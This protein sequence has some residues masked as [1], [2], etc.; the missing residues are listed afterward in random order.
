MGRGAGKQGHPTRQWQV[1]RSRCPKPAPRRR[2]FSVPGRRVPRGSRARRPGPTCPWDVRGRRQRLSRVPVTPV[3]RAGTSGTGPAR[4][5]PHPGKWKEAHPS[6][7]ASDQEP[8]REAPES[9]T[10]C[11]QQ[12]SSGRRRHRHLCRALGGGCAS[13]VVTWSQRRKRTPPGGHDG[14][15]TPPSA[16]GP[17]H[18][19]EWSTPNNT[20]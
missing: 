8:L 13:G 14:N 1:T 4:S 18:G 2:E 12:H 7:S 5:G 6:R 19:S 3:R 9:P 15:D 11:G 16:C 17:G 10:R 20:H